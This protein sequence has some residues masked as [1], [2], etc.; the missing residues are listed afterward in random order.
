MS[1]HVSVVIGIG[2]MGELIAR[3]I[4]SGKH[5]LIADYNEE[6]LDN[7][8]QKLEGDGF[9]VTAQVVDVS[10]R[11]SVDS[12]AQKAASLGD[13]MQVA[14][15]AGVS[16][17][18]APTEAVIKVDALGVAYTLEAFGEVIAPNGAG[19]V[20]A[21]MAGSFVE[22]QLPPEAETALRTLPAAQLSESPILDPSNFANP[23]EAYSIAKRANQ[24]RVE[25]ASTEWG[26]RGARVNSVSP[27]I[28][29]TPMGRLELESE[30]GT[31]M[32]AMIEGSGTGRAGTP[33]D[34]ADA[35]AFLLGPDSSFITGTN[36]LVAG[37]V[38]AGVRTG[39][40]RF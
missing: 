30:S 22:G 11:E 6:A 3:R 24:L 27:G 13:V 40:I 25:S 10:S 37:G 26:K 33:S 35:A 15:T 39:T 14:H 32:R 21:S 20:I 7:L 28:I 5:L 36:I 38:V 29:S 4:G 8:A 2:G 9:S 12:L 17:T 19:I 16:P 31:A 18:Q 1:K 23:G 34:I